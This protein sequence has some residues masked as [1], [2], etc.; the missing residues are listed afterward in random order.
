MNDPGVC[1][2]DNC[3]IYNK[4]GT[5]S[6]CNKPYNVSNSICLYFGPCIDFNPAT[7][8]CR[9]CRDGYSLVSGSCIPKNCTSYSP[10]DISV[11]LECA[12]G[13]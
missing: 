6:V 8:Q 4:D 3:Q 13:F 11:C 12:K 9:S 2:A 7:N 10:A 1:V 5:C